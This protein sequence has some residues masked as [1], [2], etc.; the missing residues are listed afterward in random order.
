VQ[1]VV[2][3]PG[4]R[5]KWAATWKTKESG[6]IY[7]PPGAWRPLVVLHELAHIRPDGTD[8]LTWFF[9]I[10]GLGDQGQGMES[11]DGAA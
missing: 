3:D 11:E 7:L 1:R 4:R 2:V 6:K 5:C 10:L 9:N 8:D